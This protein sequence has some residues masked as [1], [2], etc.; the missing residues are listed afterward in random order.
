MQP[1]ST[2]QTRTCTPTQQKY[3]D[4]VE[5]YGSIAAAARALGVS[6][7]TV[8]IALRRARSTQARHDPAVHAH[9]APP[10][11]VLRGVSTLRD[12]DGAVIMQWVKTA[13]ERQQRLDLLRE[14]MASLL[15]ETAMR[16]APLPAPSAA[17]QD[18]LAVYPLADAHIGMFAWGQEAGEDFDL[19]I[20]ER[21][22]ADTQDRLVASAPTAKQ[23]LFIDLGDFMHVDNGQFRTERAGHNLDGDTRYAKVVATAIRLKQ[24]MIDRLLQ[25]HDH[26]EVW[27][28]AGNHDENSSLALMLAFEAIY[29]DEPRVKVSTNPARFQVLEYGIGLIGAAHGHTAALK[30]LPGLMAA[31]WPE[32]WGRTQQRVWYTGHVHHDSAQEHP[33]CMVETLRTASP[34]DAWTAG[35][36]YLSGRDLKCDIWHR[37]E[38]RIGRVIQKVIARD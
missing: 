28:L 5:R 11:Y 19:K 34:R 1:T 9:E 29:R 38:G 21:T 10:G 17:D 6:R 14:A 8:S 13:Q 23:A 12:A 20:A 15:D 35:R 16:L 4:A 30:T 31:Q 2:R 3:L 36:G 22:Y 26:V 18:L 7:Q 32:A 33:G 25:K 24:R 27:S 37:R